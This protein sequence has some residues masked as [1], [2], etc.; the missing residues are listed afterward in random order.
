MNGRRDEIPYADIVPLNS[1][2]TNYLGL[3]MYI[4][5]CCK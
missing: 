2:D 4:E 1:I 5:K 3:Q